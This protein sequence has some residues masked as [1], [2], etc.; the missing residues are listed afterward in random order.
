MGRGRVRVLQRA[1]LGL[2]ITAACASVVASAPAAGSITI[3][4]GQHEQ[5]T[6]ALVK[7]FEHR[8]GI[9]VQVRSADESSLANQILLEG[10]HSPADVFYSENPPAQTVLDEHHLLAPVAK[11]TLG[12]VARRYSAGDGSWVGVSARSAVLAYNTTE[13]KAS[14]LPGSLLALATPAWKGKIGFAPAETDF[15]PLL[16][17]IARLKGAPAALAWL[18][19]LTA[20]AK[21]YDDNETLIAAVNRGEVAAGLVDHYYWYRLRD[22]V[23]PGNVHSALHYFA[24][25]DPGALVDVSGASVLRSST[26]AALAQRFL[27]YLVSRPAQ[28]IIAQSESYEYPLGSGVTTHRVLVPFAKL[29][30]PRIS[31]GELGDGTYALS[32]LRQV[33]LL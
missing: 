15:Q 26:H 21:T 3:Y 20:N 18:K 24:A 8:T 31:A 12:H 9:D 5:T 27:A 32:L 19:G 22:E 17:T 6:S 16:T 1:A 28:E 33:G 10:S 2:L 13:L 29:R 11:A 7:D 4:S 14:A 25:G 23:G 30:P